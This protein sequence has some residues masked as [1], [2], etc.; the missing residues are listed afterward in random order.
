MPIEGD[1]AAA[2]DGVPNGLA[3][4]G[5]PAAMTF[6][7]PGTDTALGGDRQLWASIVAATGVFSDANLTA[8]PLGLSG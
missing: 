7:Q 8:V 3:S 5:V 1:L 6:S 2:S 4:Q